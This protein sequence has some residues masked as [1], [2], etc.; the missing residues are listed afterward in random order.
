[1]G[2][3]QR[4]RLCTLTAKGPG[5][6]PGQGNK[7][8]QA[9]KGSP[10]KQKASRENGKQNLRVGSTPVMCVSNVL[11]GGLCVAGEC[12]AAFSSLKSIQRHLFWQVFPV[13]LLTSQY[14]SLSPNLGAC[15]RRSRRTQP[16]SA[17]DKVIR[18]YLCM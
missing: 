14:Q 17:L 5:S 16:L 1:M 13:C 8:L 10:K 18:K 3:S 6:I 9:E 11:R 4:F 12:G 2:Y 7:I 15:T